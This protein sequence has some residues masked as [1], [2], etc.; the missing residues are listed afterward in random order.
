[1]EVRLKTLELVI[2]IAGLFFSGLVMGKT[3]AGSYT[4]VYGIL[5]S[6]GS[7]LP[8]LTLIIRKRYK[9]RK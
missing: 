1:M 6:L 3:I 7:V 2:V 9:L 4:M 5:F 8:P